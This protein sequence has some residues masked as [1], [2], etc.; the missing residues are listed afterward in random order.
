MNL[1][2]A[3]QRAQ[4]ALLDSGV[5]LRAGD[6]AACPL[7]PEVLVRLAP[8]SEGVQCVIGTGLTAEIFRLRHEGRDYAV[9]RARPEALVRNVDGRVSFLN[10]LQRRIELEALREREGGL[11][12]IVPTLFASLRLGLVVSPWIDSRPEQ[13]WDDRA[14]GQLFEAGGQLVREGFFEW[15]YCPGNLLDDGRQL[16]LFDFGYLYRFDPRTQLNTAG[17]GQGCPQ[18]HLAERFETRNYFAFLLELEQARGGPLAL[19]AFRREK[20]IASECY[21]K[22]ERDL[23]ARGATPTVLAW[24]ESINRH[25]RARLTDGLEALYW[26]EGWRSH[27]L[28]L[29]DDLHGESC[30]PMTLRRC[31]WMLAALT[32]EFNSLLSSGALAHEPI[33]P[34]RERL[35]EHYR[36]LRGR[37]A[38]LQMRPR[39]PDKNNCE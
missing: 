38:V 23:A 8:G 33:E 15:D 36:K 14:L 29:D 25:W 19:A 5:E 16:W 32:N 35:L 12:G 3:R 22:L 9:K 30:T 13:A 39:A 20:E 21:T 27:R 11:A 26:E 7:P 1:N 2:E 28:D 4:V 6:P 34:T 31:D 10:E 37:A 24:L 18:F 17:N